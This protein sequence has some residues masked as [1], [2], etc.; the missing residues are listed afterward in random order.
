MYTRMVPR[1]Q[2]C[3]CTTARV[4]IEQMAFAHGT[5][6]QH[7]RVPNCAGACVRLFTCHHATHASERGALA[8]GAFVLHALRLTSLLPLP[9]VP[10]MQ[11]GFESL[12][13]YSLGGQMEKRGPGKYI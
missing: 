7:T 9:V 8:S 3:L 6:A 1:V 4:L 5:S 11:H 12:D 10:G 2:M 13:N